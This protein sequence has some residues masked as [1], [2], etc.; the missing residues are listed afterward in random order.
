[1]M[2]SEN[3]NKH[4]DEFIATYYKEYVDTLKN[5]G[6]LKTPPSLT[7]L[8]VEL[9]RNGAIEVRFCNAIELIHD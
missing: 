9:Q 5:F 3:R 4:R 8:Q 6:S 1:M 7:D 2:S